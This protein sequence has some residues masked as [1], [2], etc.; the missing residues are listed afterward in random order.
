MTSQTQP[1][2]PRGIPV[3]GQFVGKSNPESELALCDQLQRPNL[4]HLSTELRKTLEAIRSVGGKPMLVGGCVRDRLIDPEIAPKDIDIEVYGCHD[5]DSLARALTS[6]GVVDDVGKSFG[7]LKVRVGDQDFDIS[8]PRRDSKTGDGHRGFVVQSDADLS[9]REA[10]G[11]RDFTINS[12]LWDP[13]TGR[14]VDYWGGMSDIKAGILRHTTAAFSEDP[15]RVLRGVQFA[16]R[17]GFRLA[18]ETAALCRGLVN[19]YSELPTERVWSEFEKIGTKGVHITAGLAALRESGWDRHFP[20]ITATYGVEQ[21]PHY[22][23]EGDVSIHTGLSANAAAR[24]A[25]A[26][27]LTGD[28]RFVIV[29]GTMVHDFGKPHH[30]QKV[31]QADGS[32]MITSHGHAEGGIQPTREFLASIGCPRQLVDRI[33]PL[34]RE[35]MCAASG[36]PTP[37]AVRRLSRRLIPATVAEWALVVAADHAG[38]GPGSGPNPAQ[39]WLD[40]ATKAGVVERPIKGILTGDHLIAAGM[41]PGPAFKPILSDALAAQD[42][43][44]FDDEDGALAWFASRSG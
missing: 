14:V 34:V 5:P 24:I 9:E 33:T 20:Q 32:F 44:A 19:S 25:D 37:A 17:F 8:L 42:D 23:P 13:E 40:S 2:Q 35:H 15:L 21:D 41:K 22:H 28:D 27:G 18:P 16:S 6:V 26:R 29:M 3:G 39:A 11:R 7:V 30:T 1:R 4:I 31:L 12:I 10:T 36:N 43:G 38:R